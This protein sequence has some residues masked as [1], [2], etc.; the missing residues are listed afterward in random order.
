M[1]W[2]QFKDKMPEGD[3]RL[4]ICGIID[5]DPL[6]QCTDYMYMEFIDYENNL[7]KPD[8]DGQAWYAPD[9]ETYWIYQKDIPTPYKED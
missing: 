6:F 5:I 7:L 1:E 3:C 9:P 2:T 8:D 4:L